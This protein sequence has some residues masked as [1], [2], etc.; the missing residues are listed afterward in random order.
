M[1]TPDQVDA[2]GKINIIVQDNLDSGFFRLMLL[3]CCSDS[4]ILYNTRT[5]YRLATTEKMTSKN[6]LK[7]SML[8][9]ALSNGNSDEFSPKVALTFYQIK[10]KL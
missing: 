4:G 5:N 3:T 1:Q 7:K 8:E 2:S 6:R 9:Y 10:K